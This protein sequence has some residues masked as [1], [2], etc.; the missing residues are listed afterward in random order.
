[1]GQFWPE[2]IDPSLCDVIYYGFGNILN[3][4]YEM[5]IWDPVFD[6]G[7]GDKGDSTVPYCDDRVEPGHGGEHDGIR[8]TL[9]LKKINNDLK[10]LFA[11]GSWKAGGQIFSDMV[12]TE[13]NRSR[14]V[15]SVIK[16][17]KHFGF[18]G[19]DISWEFPA[20]DMYNME[21]TDPQDKPRF[22]LLAQALKSV[23]TSEELLLT[24]AA[25][26]DPR[27]AENAYELDK[28]PEFVDWFNIENFDCMY[29]F[30]AC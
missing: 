17:L 27:K 15:N 23:F 22:T 4:T 13:E 30:C 26:S 10:V 3:N 18:D 7:P 16:F 21:P 1:M 24:V 14:F 6:L 12:K 9:D 11:V 2:D 25:A 28:L 5:C 8:R 20:L 19:L 29:F